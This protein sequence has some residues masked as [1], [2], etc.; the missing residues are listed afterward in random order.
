MSDILDA[1]GVPCI[2]CE[3]TI[4]G[5]PQWAGEAGPM[6]VE[7]LWEYIERFKSALREGEPRLTDPT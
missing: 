6:C 7:C 1:P 5:E 2:E 4:C 3:R